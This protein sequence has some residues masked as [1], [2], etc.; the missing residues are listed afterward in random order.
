VSLGDFLE[1]VGELLP[2]VKIFLPGASIGR[3]LTHSLH[4]T[5]QFVWMRGTQRVIGFGRQLIV[6]H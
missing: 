6:L 1:A 5:S 2:E 4:V 3:I